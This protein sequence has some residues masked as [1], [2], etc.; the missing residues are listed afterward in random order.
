MRRRVAM[1]EPAAINCF[2]FWISS[3][4]VMDH[5][6]YIWGTKI[7]LDE[8]TNTQAQHSFE[9]GRQT[10]SHPLTQADFFTQNMLAIR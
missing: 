4:V 3:N 8:G 10:V 1:H 7:S 5:L 2:A 9:R 6:C